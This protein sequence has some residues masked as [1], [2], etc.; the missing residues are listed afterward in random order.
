MTQTNR[1][2]RTTTRN[3]INRQISNTVPG[4]A[5]EIPVDTIFDCVSANGGQVVD[6]AGD[7]WTGFFCG[8]QG[9]THLPIVFG[10]MKNMF[11]HISWYRL[12]S[13]RYEIVTYVS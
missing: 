1:P 5:L 9:Q 7:P 4:Y 3:R 13:G 12:G 11:L 10:W 6:E 2:S 8:E